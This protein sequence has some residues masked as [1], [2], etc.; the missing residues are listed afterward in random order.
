VDGFSGEFLYTVHNKYLLVWAETGIG[1]LIA[2]VW[3]LVATVRQGSKC[4]LSRDALFGPLA[5][6]CTAAVIGLMVQMNLDPFR[7]GAAIH[8]LWLLAGLVSVMNRLSTNSCIPHRL[9]VAK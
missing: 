6:G 7:S 3:L 1:G 4:W 2:F 9:A 8:L 5:L